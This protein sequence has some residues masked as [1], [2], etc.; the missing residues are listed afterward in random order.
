MNE[1]KTIVLSSR[2]SQ[3]SVVLTVTLILALLSLD[4]LIKSMYSVYDYDTAK[5]KNSLGAADSYKVFHDSLRFRYAI[6][7]QA[8]AVETVHG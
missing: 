1:A 7:L 5:I 8:H 2:F 6:S 4:E 3:I